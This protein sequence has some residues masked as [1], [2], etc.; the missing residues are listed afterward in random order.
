MRSHKVLATHKYAKESLINA[1]A[2]RRK[3]Q[4]VPSVRYSR[5]FNQLFKRIRSHLL[6]VTA[7]R[8]LIFTSCL[9]ALCHL[10][11]LCTNCWRARR[12]RRC[13]QLS[14]PGTGRPMLRAG[15][16]WRVRSAHARYVEK[17]VGDD[18]RPCVFVVL[19][20]PSITGARP[21]ARQP[22]LTRPHKGNDAACW[23][24]AKR[25]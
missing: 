10:C 14:A 12:G 22:L 25:A 5:R 21:S 1:T 19:L 11:Q 6:P 7:S 15:Q 20:P 8:L 24:A 4:R 18:H 17:K 23:P 2:H 3:P 13:G 16:L 9:I